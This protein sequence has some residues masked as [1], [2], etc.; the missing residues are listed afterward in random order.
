MSDALSG[1][2][3]DLPDA[4]VEAASKAAYISMTH[5]PQPWSDDSLERAVPKA[6]AAAVPLIRARIADE[7]DEQANHEA[8]NAAEALRFAA[9]Q[10]AAGLPQLHAVVSARRAAARV[11][12]GGTDGTE[13][14]K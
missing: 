10:I 8:P 1:P 3:G 4:W 11:A 13:E 9:G 5:D 7:L 2:V 6:L 14:T 12:R